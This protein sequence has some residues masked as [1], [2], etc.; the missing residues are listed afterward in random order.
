MYCNY[1][2][3]FIVSLLCVFLCISC[4]KKM[5][6]Q[7]ELTPLQDSISFHY[8]KFTATHKQHHLDKAYELFTENDVIEERSLYIILTKAD[9]LIR[10][11]DYD[12]FLKVSYALIKHADSLDSKYYQ[13]RYYTLMASYYESTSNIEKVFVHFNKAKNLYIKQN[14]SI[15][16]GRT[17]L[18]LA[19]IQKDKND[20]YGSEATAVDGLSYLQN[21]NKK[22]DIAALYSV[23]GTNRRKLLNYKDAVDDYN[24]AISL[25][26]NKNHKLSYKN[27]L[28]ATYIDQKKYQKSI[29]LFEGILKDSLTISKSS[30]VIDNLAYSRWLQNPKLDIE[31]E[32]VYALKIRDSLNDQKGL[33]ASYTHLTEY[34]LEKNIAK[35]I[36]YGE[37]VIA[38]SRKTGTPEAELDMLRIIMPVQPEN[39]QIRDRFIHLKD[40][41]DIVNKKVSTRFAKMKYDTKEIEKKNASLKAKNILEEQQ[42]ILYG[43]IAIFIVIIGLIY[44]Y[45]LYQK[46]KREKVLEVYNTETRIS[47]KVHDELANDVYNVMVFLQK[48][49][50]KKAELSNKVLNQV[51]DIYVR[52]RNISHENNS[53]DT[54]E[55][56][57]DGLR[58]MIGDY[59]TEE[60]AIIIK[61]IENPSWDTI[62]NYKKIVVHRVLQ[63]L[64][65]NMKKHSKATVVIL[66][67]SVKEKQLVIQ[68]SDN[69]IGLPF[70]KASKKDLLN[71][72]NRIQSVEGTLN[73]DSESGKGLKLAMRFPV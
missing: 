57:T 70:I 28:A 4:D 45:F 33:I 23:I 59:N 26:S 73:F 2:F 7:T 3:K 30:R 8:Q 35:A 12:S 34:F 37:K 41:V 43:T 31:N 42:K 1:H 32:L 56:Y 50:K 19:T 6:H 13:A 61:D 51:E 49:Q 65:V 67:F 5:N 20:H 68:Y 18:S 25:T 39:T 48:V 27:N 10:K 9:A 63:E 53:I 71:M 62:D 21:S 60:I 17:L 52:T 55:D 64:M 36:N 14:D 22:D 40:S 58:D 47:K 38:I 24:K 29:A 66:T 54:S 11:K 46:H 72:E 16:A 69:G 15:N 44:F